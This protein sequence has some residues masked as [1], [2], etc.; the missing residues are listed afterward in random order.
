LHRCDFRREQRKRAWIR[1]LE[2]DARLRSYCQF[3]FT[4]IAHVSLPR[5]W[6]HAHT[7]MGWQIKIISGI[8]LGRYQTMHW[9]LKDWSLPNQNKGAK[10]SLSPLKFQ[11]L[12][13]NLNLQ[14]TVWFRPYQPASQIF[15]HSVNTHKPDTLSDND[16]L[17]NN[18]NAKSLSW[19]YIIHGNNR[20][21]EIIKSYMKRNLLTCSE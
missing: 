8:L 15:I 10:T 20:I 21:E 14:C 6:T 7:W 2:T 4:L 19:A 13:F 12:I 18:K 3:L 11:S 1:F 9:R 5:T 16:S 17:Q